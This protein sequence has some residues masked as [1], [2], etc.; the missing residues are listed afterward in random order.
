[1]CN[2]LVKKLNSYKRLQ[3]SGIFLQISGGLIVRRGIK[4]RRVIERGKIDYQI[5]KKWEKISLANG[6]FS[7]ESSPQ[8]LIL[9]LI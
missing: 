6:E 5:R 7:P 2:N 4:R 1:M 3:G 9:L 8:P